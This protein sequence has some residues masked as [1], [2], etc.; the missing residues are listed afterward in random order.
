MDRHRR[1]TGPS[2]VTIAITGVDVPDPTAGPALAAVGFAEIDVGL[3]PTLEVVRPPVDAIEAMDALTASERPPTA[4]ALTRLRTRPT[5][6]WRSD[7]EPTMVREIE[8]ASATTVAPTVT[9]RLDQRA[10]DQVLGALLGVAGPRASTRLTGVS[11]AAGWAAADRNPSSAWI[12]PF[13]DAVGARLIV[14][15]RNRPLGSVEITQPTGDYSPITAVRVGDGTRFV[16]VD[17]PAPDTTGRSKIALP[18]ALQGTTL[19]IE[20]T[21]VERRIT[22]DR[23][24]AEPV[25]LPSAI[26]EVRP[27]V[28]TAVPATVETGCRNDL[29]SVDGIPVAVSVTADV[30]D[31][32]TGASV[33]ATPCGTGSLLGHSRPSPAA[34]HAWCHHRAAGRPGHARRT[35]GRRAHHALSPG[36]RT[37]GRCAHHALSPGRRTSAGAPT[38]ASVPV[39]EPQPDVPTA[40]L[41]RP[42]AVV[43]ES[44]RTDRVVTVGACPDGCWLV[45]G[46]GYHERWE[47]EI[48]DGAG[49]TDIGA[50]QLV[51]GGFNGWWLPPG[52]SPTTVT[53]RWTAQ[54]PLT[55]AF[56]V[57]ALFVV[58]AFVLIAV[59]RRRRAGTAC[60]WPRTRLPRPAGDAALRRSSPAWYGSPARSCSSN[61]VTS[62]RRC[63]VRACCTSPG[64]RGSPASWRSVGWP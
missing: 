59:D 1:P 43:D 3:E 64:V 54:T 57:S 6:R 28:A 49:D 18:E 52:E 51:D 30:A 46:E 58:A 32:F 26:A 63:S 36:R 44:G 56:V 23:R 25:V 2:T 60:S 10:S 12:T 45:L 31:L 22:V 27:A 55:I 47:A 40:P 37:S 33:T 39:A 48:T 29:V 7:P 38:T 53:I 50:P 15:V 16:D 14:P 20:L 11:T 13:G 5:D 9:V 61:R 34:N 17:V 21:E 62:C 4:L 35:S 41:P 19:S 24:W 42:T 8:F